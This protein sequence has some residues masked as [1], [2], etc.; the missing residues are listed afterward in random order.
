MQTFLHSIHRHRHPARQ[1]ECAR[2]MACQPRCKLSF[3][4]E[5]KLDS[6]R[7]TAQCLLRV[8]RVLLLQGTCCCCCCCLAGRCCPSCTCGLCCSRRPLLASSGSRSGIS[9]R[10]RDCTSVSVGTT[11]GSIKRPP[12]LGKFLRNRKQL[13]CHFSRG[14]V[15]RF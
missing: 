15:Y 11:V 9:S 8:Y 1:Q 13:K 14:K 5:K 12:Q 7:F 2:E 4:Q 10:V 6:A 3:F